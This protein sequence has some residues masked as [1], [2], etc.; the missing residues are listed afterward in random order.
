MLLNVPLR[1]DGTFDEKEYE[2][3]KEFKAWMKV[4]S[5]S[6]FDT[7]PWKIFGEGPI[8][9]ATIQ[10][11]AQG[12]ND[13]NYTKAGSNEIRFTQKGK[14]LYA[15]AL[16][17]P[18]DHK[19][20]IKSLAKGSKLWAKGIKKIELLGYGKVKYTRTNDALTVELPEKPCNT[21]MPVLKIQ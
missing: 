12:F 5:E 16:A 14:L 13:G 2:I 20:I 9:E 17:W 10:I 8:A 7:R 15:T 1:A 4:N 11:N 19:I 6:I 3:L 21:L 18:E